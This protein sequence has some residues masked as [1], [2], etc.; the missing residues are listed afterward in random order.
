M[1]EENDLKT[2]LVPAVC[3]QCGA[4]LEVD[5]TQDAAVCPYCNTPYIVDKA[6]QNYNVQNAKIE[7]ADTVKI[8][9]KGTADSFFG[10]LGKQLSESR[11]IG[12]AH[13]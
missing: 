3:T 10:F 9:M 11:E 13:V 2:R 12:R 1:S 4:K 8:D 7:H 6:I 5:P